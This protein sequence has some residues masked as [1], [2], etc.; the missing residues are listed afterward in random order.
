M[1]NKTDSKIFILFLLNEINYPLDYSTVSDVMTDAGYVEMFDFAE[2][3][4]ELCE[5]GHV[6]E[7][8]VNGEK[9]YSISDS[10]RV[11]ASELQSELLESIREKSRKSAARLLSLRRRGA[12]LSARTKQRSDGKLNVT[13]E[14]SDAAGVILSVTLPVSSNEEAKKICENFENRPER[15]CRGILSVLS[16]D[17]D[18]YLK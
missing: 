15:I 16:G 11:V 7:E 13:C 9:L 3:F 17:T 6:T 18:Y 14:L 8:I 12:K 1:N 5:L 4:S 10:G 2:C